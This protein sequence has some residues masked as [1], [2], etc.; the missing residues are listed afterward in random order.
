[1]QHVVFTS[2][3]FLNNILLY[4]IL[5]CIHSPVDEHLGCFSFLATII[6]IMLLLI[7]VGFC[8]DVH[9]YFSWIYILKSGISRLY[10]N[11][12]YHFEEV[13]NHYPKQLL[14]FIFP[15]AIIGIP[16]L[17]ILM[18]TCYLFTTPSEQMRSCSSWFTFAFL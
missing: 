11:Y 10:V 9:F 13:P 5:H 17:H 3:L 2:F 12:V 6:W 18:N 14:Y 4:D 1:M 7:C 16:F 15:I 8:V